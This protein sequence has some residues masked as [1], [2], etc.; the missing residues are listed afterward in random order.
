MHASGVEYV[1]GKAQFFTDVEVSVSLSF[2]VIY[3]TI[4]A[5]RA[6]GY[7]LVPYLAE[8]GLVVAPAG[9][10][11]FQIPLNVE[12]GVAA[13]KTCHLASKACGSI[14]SSAKSS[15]MVNSAV[16]QSFESFS[17]TTS[18]EV[19]SYSTIQ[20]TNKYCR[21]Q[22][23]NGFVCDYDLINLTTLNRLPIQEFKGGFARTKKTKYEL[24]RTL[25]DYEI[26][27]QS[28]INANSITAY[29]NGNEQTCVTPAESRVCLAVKEDT[30]Y[31][32]VGLT[33]VLDISNPFSRCP[34]FSSGYRLTC[35]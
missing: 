8:N 18:V 13:F 31:D 5:E 22:D 9:Q 2:F 6:S 1:V 24:T 33:E 26:E 27:L 10:K 20:E 28:Q 4:V 19:V 32:D 14:D 11:G 29:V 35:S 15:P 30:D 3:Q 34:F 7:Y 12:D 16:L 21:K 17:T 23:A 25:E